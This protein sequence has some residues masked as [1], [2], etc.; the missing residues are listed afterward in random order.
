MARLK[1]ATVIK[2]NKQVQVY[3]HFRDD[4]YIDYADCHTTYNPDELKFN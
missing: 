4:K 1:T 3:R 2:T